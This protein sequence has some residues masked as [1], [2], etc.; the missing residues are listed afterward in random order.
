M[1]F[2]YVKLWVGAVESRSALTKFKCQHKYW[3]GE[4]FKNVR[5]SENFDFF[6]ILSGFCYTSPPRGNQ[7]GDLPRAL[8][9]S[10]VKFGGVRVNPNY[11]SFLF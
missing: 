6:E 8:N 5:F 2:N 9:F 10:G 11:K 4:I 7:V 3:K 1:F